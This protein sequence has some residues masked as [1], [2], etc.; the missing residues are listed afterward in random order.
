MRPLRIAVV[1]TG[2]AGNTVAHRLHAAGHDISVFEA[3]SHVGG[4][5]HTHAI[6]H[7]G[8]EHAIDTGFIVFNDRT[9][10]N[11]MALLDEL[12]VLSKPSTMSF[13][14][15]NDARA[16]EYNGSTLGGLFVQRRNLLRPGFH[17]MLREILR[18]HREAPRLLERDSA[19]TP[20]GEF[21]AANGFGGRFV[22]DYLV[23]MGASIWST[24]PARMLGFPARFFVRFLFNHGMLTVDD[25]PQ[26]RVIRG[27]SACYVERLSARWRDRIRLQTPVMRV[28]RLPDGVL[29]TAQGHPTE[30]FDHVFMACHADQALALL[31][32]PS[33]EERSI[34][35]AIPFQPNE[36]VLHT[37]TS[38]LPRRRRAWAA[39]NYHV[40]SPASRA[41]ALTYNMNILQGL[42]SAHTFCVTLNATERIDPR[43]ILR[44]ISYSHPLFTPEGV[45]AQARHAE[46]S[47]VRRTHYC[48]A[49]WRYG[50][51]EDGV[52]SALNALERFEE[53]RDGQRD[54]HR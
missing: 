6:V 11:F 43:R 13:S 16:L 54:L 15:R 12:D 22:D 34:L 39:W 21:L 36:A 18:F 23:P 27:G 48:G 46:I 50:F 47:G 41:V 53:T 7:E 28:Q 35:G 40:M 8:E 33:P 31:V 26:W 51:H 5:T 3:G 30:R 38:L 49:Y 32:D 1:G 42:Q 2:I 19:E 45:A 4:H 44:T 52:V 25:R 9:Y 29:V 20:L 10:P 24:D 14:V 37:D 17:W